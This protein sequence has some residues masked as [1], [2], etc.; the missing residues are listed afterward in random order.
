MAQSGLPP[1]APIPRRYTHREGYTYFNYAQKSEGVQHHRVKALCDCP[2]DFEFGKPSITHSRTPHWPN[3]IRA[4]S[5]ILR[6]LAVQKLSIDE[7]NQVEA[8]EATAAG[9]ESSLYGALS[10]VGA[11]G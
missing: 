2:I 5:R 4:G 10:P 1:N 8:Q 6:Q 3:E 7:S 11:P 9:D